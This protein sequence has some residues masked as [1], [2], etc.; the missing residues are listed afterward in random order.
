MTKSLTLATL[1]L[2]FA[3]GCAEDTQESESST[4]PVIACGSSELRQSTHDVCAPMDA[5]AVDGEGG[6]CWCMLGYAWNG[7]ECVMLANCACEGTDCSKLTLDKADCEAA[8]SSC[9]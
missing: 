4:P 2:V 7:S 5:E 3:F 8:H 6:G 1:A 9:N